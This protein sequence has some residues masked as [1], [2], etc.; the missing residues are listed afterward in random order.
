MMQF[1]SKN[2]KNYLL[3]ERKWEIIGTEA[4]Q[5]NGKTY[6]RNKFDWVN[7][8]M[9]LHSLSHK[10]KDGKEYFNRSPSLVIN[11]KNENIRGYLMSCKDIS[12]FGCYYGGIESEIKIVNVGY[13]EV[14]NL[15][16]FIRKIPKN[17]RKRIIKMMFL[18]DLKKEKDIYAF[19]IL[20]NR[21][22]RY[23]GLSLLTWGNDKG[24]QFDRIIPIFTITS[25]R[26]KKINCI[27]RY[28]K[29]L[30]NG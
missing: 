8:D 12:D 21:L 19:D 22:K 3:S 24:Y 30:K 9:K 2:H 4:Y 25:N 20:L 15:T 14:Q 18:Y 13:N 27:F 1:L 10:D 17:S 5:A 29:K 6:S 23:F 11:G 28:A 26:N 16:N 7:Y